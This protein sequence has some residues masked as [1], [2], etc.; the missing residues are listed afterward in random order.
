MHSLPMIIL[1]DYLRVDVEQGPPG[2]FAFPCHVRGVTGIAVKRYF[3]KKDANM[4]YLLTE[5]GRGQLKTAYKVLI[6]SL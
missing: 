6:S 5:T 1:D 2:L 4:H 3:Y